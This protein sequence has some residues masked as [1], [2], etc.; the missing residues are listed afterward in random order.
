MS[1]ILTL[2]PEEEAR[3]REKARQQGREAENYAVDLILRD[4]NGATAKETK[5]ESLAEMLTGRIGL[6]ESEELPEGQSLA[7]A[8]EGLIGV[9][10]SS[11]KNG[12]KVSHVAENT[13]EEFTKILVEKHKAGHL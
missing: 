13:G 3:L 5:S 6:F 9:L 2:A 4:I 1:I 11:Q 8:L 10:D 7:E 12:G